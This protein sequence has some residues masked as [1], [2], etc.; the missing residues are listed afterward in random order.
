MPTDQY[1]NWYPGIDQAPWTGGSGGSGGAGCSCLSVVTTAPD[2]A[3]GDDGD[4]RIDSVTGTIYEKQSGAWV[5]IGSLGSTQ[6]ITGA[7]DDPNVA[8]ITPADPTKIAI[9][10]KDSDENIEWYWRV[11]IQEWRQSHG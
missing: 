3:D 11:S 8:T 2:D 1:G 5:A 7:V 9:Y 4:I 6:V 10:R